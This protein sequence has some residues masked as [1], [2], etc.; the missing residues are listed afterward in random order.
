VF[1]KAISV[2]S[3]SNP[4][5]KVVD[6][7]KMLID[8]YQENHKVSETEKTKREQIQ[9]E[10]RIEVEKIQ[11]QRAVLETYFE[12][13][14]SERKLMI[15]GMFDALDKGIEANNIELI[16]QSLGSIVSI[17]KESPLK[18]IQKMMDDFHNDDV[19]SITI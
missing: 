7:M 5:A 11:A 3:K 2:A 1:K 6:G 19:D 9:A 4:P 8:A 17:A 10:S 12:N 15:N 16:Q 14:F 13:I 18:G